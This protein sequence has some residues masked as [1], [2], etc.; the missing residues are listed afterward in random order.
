MPVLTLLITVGRNILR[1]NQMNF[2]AIFL[3]FFLLEK[4]MIE[5]NRNNVF[6]K[7]KN[8]FM[9]I[10]NRKYVIFLSEFPQSLGRKKNLNLS[11]A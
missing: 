11:S 6:D 8:G 5:L 4:F 9:R 7:R 2:L 10:P 1:N 3:C